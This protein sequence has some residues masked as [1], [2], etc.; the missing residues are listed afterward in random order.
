MGASDLRVTVDSA[1]LRCVID[2]A[3][4]LGHALGPGLARGLTRVFETWLTRSFWQ[5]LDASELLQRQ[6]CQPGNAPLPDVEALF[7]W[8]SLR[9]H[10]DAGSWPLRW[11]GDSLAESQLHGTA[12]ETLV[13]RYEYLAGALALRQQSGQGSRDASAHWRGPYDPLACAADAL[14]LS[15]T[16]GGAVI[17]T[18]HSGAGLP[19]GAGGRPA[20][21]EPWPVQALSRLRLP[22]ER[23]PLADVAG[24]SLFA[25]ER[26]LVR[27]ALASA[28]L[29]PL[30]QVL[31]PL[32]VVH[33]LVIPG[34]SDDAAAEAEVDTGADDD[35]DTVVRHGP[36]DP[37]R[38]A[39]AWWY[40]V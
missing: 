9:D 32:A 39:R 38:Q 15:A 27:L 14:A 24:R 25:A 13:E 3:L 20:D 19:G 16:L 8:M 12:D 31:G 23:L 26:E 35:A 30:V 7:E 5:V 17:L 2:P 40:C 28:G 10:T 33:V 22:V 11:V 36:P 34:G 18:L 21:I 37:W 1:K 29:A 6:P 4:A